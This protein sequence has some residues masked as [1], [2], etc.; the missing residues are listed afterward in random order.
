MHHTLATGTVLAVCAV[1]E[2]HALAGGVGH[3]AIDKRAVDGHVDVNELGLTIDH[4][5][6]TKHHGG[7]DQ[8]VY[9]YGED[10]ARRWAQELGR[11]L[12][13]GWFGENLRIAGIETTDATI[14][15]RWQVGDDLELEVTIARTPCR[16]FA[17]WAQEDQWIKRFYARADVGCYLRVVAPGRVRAGDA[18]RVVSR[19]DHGVLIRHLITGPDPNSLAR[20]LAVADLPPKVMRDAKR[21]HRL[22]KR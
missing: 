20:L 4:V 3:S 6:D 5:C 1:H 12:P 22:A 11:D 21:W 10:E 16:T 14:G 9:A 7:I 2:E 17:D 19:P 8:A 13:Y 15:E 18:V